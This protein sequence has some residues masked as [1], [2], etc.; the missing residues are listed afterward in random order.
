MKLYELPRN[1]CFTLN[2][3][4]NKEIYFFKS[5]DGAYSYCLNDQN[6][7][8]HFGASTEVNHIKPVRSYF[9]KTESE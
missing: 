6:D 5:I 7:V 1:S 9:S 8:I 2:G 3:D 4:D